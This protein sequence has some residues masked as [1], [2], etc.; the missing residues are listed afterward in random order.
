MIARVVWVDGHRFGVHAQNNI[1]VVGIAAE[2]GP[3]DNQ[4][5]T[6]ANRNEHPKRE[7]LAKRVDEKAEFSRFFARTFEFACVA[8]LVA[9]CAAILFEA[10]QTS[11]A[12]PL[13]EILAAL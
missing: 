12:E 11:F 5:R 10:V 13:S 7:T 4:R 9:S 3:A 2:V 8:V 1:N 6:S